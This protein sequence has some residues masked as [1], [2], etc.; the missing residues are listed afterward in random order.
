M[1]MYRKVTGKEENYKFS[2]D[3]VPSYLR[4]EIDEEAEKMIGDQQA[5]EEKILALKIKVWL[6][7]EFKHLNLKKTQT[8]RDLI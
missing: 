1:L 8:L 5:L 3:F 4:N 7:G 2:N 6:S